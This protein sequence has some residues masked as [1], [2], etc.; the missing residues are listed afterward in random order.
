[1]D[2][3]TSPYDLWRYARFGVLDFEGV[4]ERLGEFRTSDIL[5]G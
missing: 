4:S 2:L 1:V 5:D 3:R